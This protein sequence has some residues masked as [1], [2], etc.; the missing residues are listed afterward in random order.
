MSVAPGPFNSRRIR[1]SGNDVQFVGNS[2][3]ET[4]AGVKFST[5]GLPV[6]P[7]IA[8][9]LSLVPL[10]ARPRSWRTISAGTRCFQS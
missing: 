7:K 10:L 9:E 5:Y 2:E 8:S 4:P 1:P 6:R 3:V